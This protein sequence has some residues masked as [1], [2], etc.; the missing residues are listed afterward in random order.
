MSL[1]PNIKRLLI[2]IGLPAVIIACIIFC[3][4]QYKSYVGEKFRSHLSEDISNWEYNQNKQF[5]SMMEERFNIL[6]AYSAELAE[7]NYLDYP[8]E[9]KKICKACEKYGFA[10][11]TVVGP[12]KLYYK[13][14]GETVDVSYRTYLT[15]AL[16]GKTAV[17]KTCDAETDGKPMLVFS[18]PFVADGKIEGAV[19]GLCPVEVIDR[20][21]KSQAVSGDPDAVVFTSNGE[22]IASYGK[23]HSFDRQENLF[24]A[25]FGL[26]NSFADRLEADAKV[27]GDEYEGSESGVIT[28]DCNNR[29]EYA[30]YRATG[31]DGWFHMIIVDASIFDAILDDINRATANAAIA[32]SL[33]AVLLAVGLNVIGGRR[34]RQLELVQHKRLEDCMI[35]PLTGLFSKRGFEYEAEEKLKLIPENKIC[36]MVSFEIIAFRSFNALYGFDKG[37]L[38]LKRI[39]DVARIFVQ[40]NEVC[41]HLFADRFVWLMYGD[42]TEEMK[43]NMELAY[44]TVKETQ[45]P[46]FLCSGIYI[47]EDRSLS[48][49]SMVDKATIAKSTVKGNYS[50]GFAVY[51]DTMLECQLEDAELVATMMQGMDNGEFIDYYQAKYKTDSEKI[52]GAEALVRWSKPNGELIA[53]GRFISLFEKNGFIR[54]LDIYMLERVCMMLRSGLDAGRHVVP[55]SVNF[56]RVHLY[57]PNFPNIVRDVLEKYNI[58]PELIE[59]ELTESAFLMEPHALNKVVDT[60][61]EYGF[62]VAIDDFG[63]GFSSLNM[64][65]DVSV[66]VLK[67]DMKFLEGFEH[68]GKVGTVV[69]SVVRM[70]KWLGIPVVAEGVETKEQVDFLGT[71]GCDIVQGYYFAR[72][73]CRDA[74]EQL[75]EHDEISAVKRE[76]AATITLESINAVLGGDSL[77]TALMDGIVGGL[78]LYEMSG[79]RLEAIRVNRGYYELMGYP[80]MASFTKDSFNVIDEI[81]P[82]DSKQFLFSCKEAVRTGNVQSFSTRRYNFNGNLLHF[83]GL[84]KHLGGRE[85]K[86]LLCI[87]FLDATESMKEARNKELSKYSE[88]LYGIYDEIFEVNFKTNEFRILSSNRARKLE[89]TFD[90]RRMLEKWMQHTAYSE[91]R[92]ILE[93]L[94][95]DAENNVLTLPSSVEYRINGED[96]PRWISSST[97]GVTGGSYLVCNLDITDKKQIELFVER[98]EA[99]HRKVERDATT[100]ALSSDTMNKL[101]REQLLLD[102]TNSMSALIL[103]HISNF[104]DLSQNLGRLLINAFLKEIAQRISVTFKEKDIIG[105]LWDDTFAVFM[106]GIQSTAIA[107][108]KAIKVQTEIGEIVLPNNTEIDCRVGATVVMPNGRSYDEVLSNAKAA[109]E[110]A[111]ANSVNR[112]VLFEGK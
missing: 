1:K 112:C 9:L 103:I 79:N 51:D 34:R 90:L 100:G 86:P 74:F 70:A 30:V 16:D 76:P 2:S 106:I 110:Q 95:K 88:A 96:G 68:G 53:P 29:E 45:L 27:S 98:M 3:S 15:D 48:I 111:K 35:D 4:L 41:G 19:I 99:L 62:T 109:L 94:L 28:F 44:L 72:P 8:T 58:S 7:I 78:G 33:L 85:E 84:I 56:S 6:N 39:G 23:N 61:H 107:L 91:D 65:K 20:D 5:S 47:V 83:K 73:I 14:N 87:T 66:D 102:D 104:E 64:L 10:D 13:T 24:S 50:L 21:L 32:V 81:Y 63:S 49:S 108:S 37:D 57:D 105:R 92:I 17:E 46:F 11:I 93:S 55:V 101:L 71:L 59:I 31:I 36:A 22:I 54:K 26:E 75:L 42:S 18:V 67:I 60:L 12:N 89:K 82:P 38:L 77:L 43:N 52:A 97:V 80:D 69:T 40:E 25:L